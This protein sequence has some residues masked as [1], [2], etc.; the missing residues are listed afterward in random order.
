MLDMF[1]IRP[2]LA[3]VEEEAHVLPVDGIRKSVLDVSDGW[4]LEGEQGCA[5]DHRSLVLLFCHVHRLALVIEL[6]QVVV[7]Q[8]L[9]V[10][11]AHDNDFVWR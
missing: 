4:H 10:E 1:V 2:L 9:A 6:D 8:E 11:A 5:L 3:I 7:A